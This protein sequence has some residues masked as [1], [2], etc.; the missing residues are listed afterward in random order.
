MPSFICLK[1]Q[2]SLSPSPFCLIAA[3]DKLVDQRL[4]VIFPHCVD[5]EDR[6]TLA[7]KVVLLESP[8]NV[9]QLGVARRKKTRVV[10]SLVQ[11]IARVEAAGGCGQREM[12]GG[13]RALGRV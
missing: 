11:R 13:A 1:L 8:N 3:G 2:S 7:V 12:G 4:V 10:A 9:K 6:V 5:V